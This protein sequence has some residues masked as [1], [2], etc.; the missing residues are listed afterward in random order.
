MLDGGSK[1]SPT[2]RIDAWLVTDIHCEL[3]GDIRRQAARLGV[4]P[5]VSSFS[6][7]Q[8]LIEPHAVTHTSH[9][10]FG[11]L[12][13]HREKKIVWAPEFLVFPDWASRADLMFAEAASW[14]RPILFRG[15]VGGHSSVT[16]VARDAKAHQVARLVFAHIGR[17]TIRKL[18]AGEVP[19]F[20]EFGVQG[21]IYR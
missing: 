12:I 3:I 19:A 20:G 17:G 9:E 14:D 16:E 15:K 21:K 10:T 11:Y 5:H 13:K 1:T 2:G 18:D 4:E 8:L 7:G 6:A